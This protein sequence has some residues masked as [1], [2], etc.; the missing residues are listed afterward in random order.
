VIGQ[1]EEKFIPRKKELRDAI[2]VYCLLFVS[3]S[4]IYNQS[5]NKFLMLILV[6]SVLAWALFSD[7]KINDRFVLYVCVFTGFLLIIHIY[8]DNSL[9]FSSV[10]GTTIKLLIAYFIL[11]TVGKNI[12]ETYVK[13]VVFLAVI[14]LFGYLSDSLLLFD[15]LIRKLPRVGD[16]GY[17]GIFY[18]F[19]F[20][21]HIDRNNS[22]FFEPG[23]YQIFLNVALFMLFFA[24]TTFCIRKK[25][26]FISILVITLGT[27][28]STTGYLIFG[29]LFFLLIIKSDMVSKQGKAVLVGLLVVATIVFTA[30]FRSVI[31]EKID[32]FLAI[33][34][35]TDTQDRRSFDALVD[36]EIF[37]RNILGVGY[38]R[39]F[40]EFNVIG[41]VREGNASSNGLT[42][43][44]AVYGLPFFLFLFG[45]FFSFF[46][47]FFN[48]I[49][50]RA[51]PFMMLLIFLFSEAYYVFTPYCLAIIAAIFV[52]G[53]IKL[54]ENISHE[55][56]VM[57][58]I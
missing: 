14:S 17:E 42:K 46:M 49:I 4:H 18:T 48:G 10:V 41:Q 37:K 1:Q 55:N 32:R 21:G 56:E 15:G 23:A 43:T 19:R 34:D 12:V 36:I 40:Q 26:I 7:R 6:I 35:I 58:E 13:V 16:L 8:T 20:R 22:I 44:M 50:M 24:K 29:T 27:T 45:S 54:G 47:I 53:G 25:W 9:S 28:F 51:I 3:G 38:V 31:F 39:Y 11:K 33:Q 57:T 2:L 52:F 30:Q 5:P